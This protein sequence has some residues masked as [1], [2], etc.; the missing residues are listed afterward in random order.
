MAN[1]PGSNFRGLVGSLA[2]AESMVV[3]KDLLNRLGSENIECREDGMRVDPGL[4]ASYLTNS[5]IQGAETA[6]VVLLIGCNPRVEAPLFNARLRKAYLYNDAL[7]CYIGPKQEFNYDAHHLGDSVTLLKDIVSGT[8][9]LAKILSQAQVPIAPPTVFFFF[10][11][12]GRRKEDEE[13]PV[14]LCC[15]APGSDRRRR[16]C[17]A[18]DGG[19]GWCGAATHRRRGD[20]V[21]GRSDGPEGAQPDPARHLE[22]VQRPAHRRLPCGWSRSGHRARCGRGAPG[23]WQEGMCEVFAACL[24]ICLGFAFPPAP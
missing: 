9:P 11:L 18:A 24:Y 19:G 15:D 8:H 1:V 10:S 4:R 7:V 12:V 17:V 3:L 23:S 13:G 16:L 14:L 2:D 21:A 20:C 5:T 6:D 22:R